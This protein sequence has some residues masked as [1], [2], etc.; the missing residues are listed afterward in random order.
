MYYS[1]LAE[2]AKYL[3]SSEEGVKNMMTAL[4]EMVEYGRQEGRQEGKREVAVRMLANKDYSIESIAF[5]TDFTVDE[6]KELENEQKINQKN[7]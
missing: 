4:D 1:I 6:I 3:K 5:A 7:K 2:R